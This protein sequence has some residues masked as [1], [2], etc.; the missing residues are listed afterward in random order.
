M[1]ARKPRRS[2]IEAS[3]KI[4]AHL[5]EDR[6]DGFYFEPVRITRTD[7]CDALDL[8]WRRF[9]RAVA[10]LHKNHVIERRERWSRMP[11]LSINLEPGEILAFFERMK[12][13]EKL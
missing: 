8:H 6:I 10:F 3:E 2:M 4:L 11:I 12:S 1:R 7:L 13:C 9:D 5:I